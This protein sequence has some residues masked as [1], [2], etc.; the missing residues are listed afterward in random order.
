MNHTSRGSVYVLTAQ[1][2][3]RKDMFFLAQGLANLLLLGKDV[4]HKKI[5]GFKKN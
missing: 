4:N 1:T 2:P 5:K 3:D